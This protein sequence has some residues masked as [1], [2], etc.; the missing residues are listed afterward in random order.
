MRTRRSSR[1]CGNSL[2]SRLTP[3]GRGIVRIVFGGLR[4]VGQDVDEAAGVADRGG[5]VGEDQ[6]RVAEV[7]GDP[8]DAQHLVM[9]RPDPGQ[10][11]DDPAA[12]E[13]RDGIAENFGPGRVES[14]DPG[15]PQ[16]DHLDVC[17]LGQFEQEAVG[18][19][20]EQRT[21]DP[22]GHDVL[23]EQLALSPVV[24]A[25]IEGNLIHSDRQPGRQIREA[26][27]TGA[28]SAREVTNR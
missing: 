24:I 23:S 10:E 17:D 20:E 19:G 6:V 16:D 11:H 15:Q 25:L 21:V 8:Q 5:R 26:T 27:E 7:F 1:W 9:G 13:A 14:G 18:G 2:S 28:V 22:V 3:K 12:F 4:G